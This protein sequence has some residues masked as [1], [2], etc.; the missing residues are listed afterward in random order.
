MTALCRPSQIGAT[1][2]IE[3]LRGNVQ[4]TP[5]CSDGS[6]IWLILEHVWTS[7][8]N[9][10]GSVQEAKDNLKLFLETRERIKVLSVELS[11]ALFELDENFES[12][13]LS[14]D[15]FQSSHGVLL[16]AGEG[17]GQFSSYLLPKIK[18]LTCQFDFKYWPTRAELVQAIGDFETA[19]PDPTHIEYPETVIKGRRADIKNFVLAF[20]EGFTEQNGLP[21]KFR[22]SNN[23][24]AE[25]MNV[26]LNRPPDDLVTGDAI[27]TVRS[28]YKT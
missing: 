14:R 11:K 20:D 28:R 26:V 9:T 24:M 27:K 15:D 3:N 12:T 8:E 1:E 7:S 22:F 10:K 21:D 23:A 25:I 18:Q 5:Y 6:H 17:N 16:K 13:G 19:Q 4:T 2:I